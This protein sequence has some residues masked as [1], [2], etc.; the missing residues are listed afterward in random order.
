[1]NIL[2]Q[3]YFTALVA[4]LLFSHTH[5]IFASE[6]PAEDN[7]TVTEEADRILYYTHGTVVWGHEFGF[8]KDPKN[9]AKDMLWL[10]L[11]SYEEAVENF[12]DVEATVVLEVDG[13]PY[14]AKADILLTGTIGYSHIMYLS[15]WVAGTNIMDALMKGHALK[16]SIREPSAL[17]DLMDIKED[18]FSLEGF[19]A[20]REKAKNMCEDLIPDGLPRAEG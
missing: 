12:K 7:W 16:A 2:R 4:V 19:A 15:N 1:M 20:A 5:N 17:V 9:S 6:L 3:I 8:F 11:S 18:E 14:E 10:S 13:V